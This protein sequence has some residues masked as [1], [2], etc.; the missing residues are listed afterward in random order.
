MENTRVSLV[1]DFQRY[2]SIEQ[3]TTPAQLESV[4]R[5]RYRVYCEEFHYEPTD[6]CP[7]QLETDEFDVHAVHS[8][9]VH[10][11]SG[12]PA[13]CAR[14][15]QAD[16]QRLMPMEKF[17]SAA[18]DQDILRSFDGRRDTVCEFS[19]LGVDGAFRR[20]PGEH[21]SRFGEISA[22]ELCSREQR[23]FPLVAMATI[24][25]ALA[26]S[27]VIGRP[28]CFAMMEPFLPRLL[29]RSGLLARP[30]GDQIEY[31]GTRSPFYWE[32]R[33]GVSTL[34]D[35]FREFYDTILADFTG[36]TSSGQ[37]SAI[38]SP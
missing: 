23:T 8:L 4:Y 26:L 31:H 9:V 7:N 37:R 19:R 1:E 13:G 36:S 34:G 2:F 30:A 14:L 20:R 35:E 18:I 27:E 3:V 11:A 22:L 21:E 25:S 24:L 29:R 5:V 12:M 28:N 6:A 15:V 17:C 33:E 32:T 38:V 16:E 10:R